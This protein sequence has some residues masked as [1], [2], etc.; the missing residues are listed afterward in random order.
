QGVRRQNRG[1]RRYR[2]P[3]QNPG[4]PQ[5]A[6]CHGNSAR[7][8]QGSRGRL[9]AASHT[10]FRKT[11]L[12]GSEARQSGKLD[13]ARGVWRLARL[14][15]GGNEAAPH[16]A[17]LFA[18]TAEKVPRPIRA[19]IQALRELAEHD[20]PAKAGT[21]QYV[22]GP[23]SFYRLHQVRKLAEPGQ[24]LHAFGGVAEVLEIRLDPAQLAPRGIVD[25]E[26]C[27]VEPDEDLLHRP[28]EAEKVFQETSIDF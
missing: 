11:F 9:L 15:Q 24:S 2:L 19:D 6:S 12:E 10:G 4:P 18:I 26:P 14:V 13:E 22:H 28:D 17:G 8:Q 25:P 16:C 21:F 5:D 1:R 23:K 7:R 27:Q 3:R 20:L